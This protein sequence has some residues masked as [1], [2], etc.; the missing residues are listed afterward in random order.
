ME[1]KMRI[2]D[3]R[4]NLRSRIV[5][6]ILK[7]TGGYCRIQREKNEKIGSDEGELRKEGGTVR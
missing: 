6:D 1:K 5:G 2:T 7:N 3:I 4:T